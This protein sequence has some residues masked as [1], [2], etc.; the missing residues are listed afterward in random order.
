MSDNKKAITVEPI[1]SSMPDMKGIM[2]WFKRVY[3]AH[4]GR[5][6]MSRKDEE[7]HPS[8]GLVQFNRVTGTGGGRLFGSH[9]A[10]H[11]TTIRLQISK[12]AKSH[13]L[14]QNWFMPRGQM[15]EVELSAAQ[16]AELLTTMNYGSGVPCT[17][18]RVNNEGVEPPPPESA[19]EHEQIR[20]GFKKR[21][22]EMT[23]DLKTASVEVDEIMDK[24]Y[25][26]KDD[27]AKV[28]TTFKMFIQEI[29]QNMPFALE[30][31]E[32][33]AEKVVTHAKA[34]VEAFVHNVITKAGLDKLGIESAKDFK[35]LGT[36]DDDK[37]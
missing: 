12:A 7:T 36:E 22:D 33:S 21:M 10:D 5:L 9:L 3:W 25:I 17:I 24:D 26:N 30:Q 19:L 8:Y 13:D 15:I 29:R 31:F 1:E 18:R 35:L 28:K 37:D 23:K 20:K 27:R 34:E 16:F 2:E 11:H 14:S 6:N 32:E 4:N